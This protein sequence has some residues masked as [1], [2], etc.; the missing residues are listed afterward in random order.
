MVL[1][2][3]GTDDRRTIQFPKQESEGNTIKVEGRTGLVEKIVAEIQSKVAEWESQ[4][5]DVVD[6]PID[7]HRGLIGRGGET[8]RKL[9]EQLKVSIDIPRQGDGKTGV[10]ISGLPENVKAA[11]EHI[12]SLVKE[13]QGETVEL[14]R[15][16]HH[17]I[18]N[19][20]QIFRRLRSDFH[21]TVDHAG[22]AIP[23]KPEPTQS[24]SNGGSLPLITDEDSAPDT[25]K[26]TVVQTRSTEEGDIPWVLRGSAD[27]VAR[28]K[29][30]IADALAQAQKSD[31][32]GFL[33]L[34]D[35][36]TYR[37]VIGPGGSK[38]TSIRKQSG[39]KVNVPRD[40][41][42]IEIVGS[43]EG[44]EKAKEMILQAVREGTSKGKDPRE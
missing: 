22:H 10:K 41:E 43:K 21:V 39:C 19:N 11:K 25:H 7:Q 24:G 15:A 1:R 9:E 4:V 29:K 23:P 13:Q 6:V 38:V 28:A 12:Q 42:P 8:K 37:F 2:A 17:A 30:A 18:S 44:V 33:A 16:M 32:T 20:G 14:P 5:G 27:N 34:S 3:G 31:T 40:H 26:W 35:P 36:K